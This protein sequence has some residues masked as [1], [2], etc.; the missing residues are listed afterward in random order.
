MSEPGDHWHGP[1]AAPPRKAST[2]LVLMVL[3]VAVG[4]A[5]MA[6]V[7]LRLAVIRLGYAI[8]EKSGERRG[9]EEDNRKLRL[10]A[11]LL[12][13]PARIE[14]LAREQLGMERPDPARIRVVRPGARE[15]ADRR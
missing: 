4:G 11:S 10:E 15:L 12:R 9:L 13:S 5:A 1:W 6:H 8:S 7:S 3:F 14:R 2:V